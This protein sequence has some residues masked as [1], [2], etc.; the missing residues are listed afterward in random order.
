MHIGGFLEKDY[1]SSS[2]EC[3]R[4]YFWSYNFR[5]WVLFN[6]QAKGSSLRER[7]CVSVAKPSLF[8]R[9]YLCWSHGRDSHRLRGYD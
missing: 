7:H 4:K 3:W 6:I 5:S 1:Y 8:R 2:L 9:T